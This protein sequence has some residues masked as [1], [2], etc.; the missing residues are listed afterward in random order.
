MRYQ[1]SLTSNVQ[2]YISKI[3]ANKIC[4]AQKPLEFIS[5]AKDIRNYLGDRT[6]LNT[7]DFIIRR[8]IQTHHAEILPSG[9]KIPNLADGCNIPWEADVIDSLSKTLA[10]RSKE[11]GTNISKK[12]WERYFSGTGASKREK[13]FKIAFTLEMDTDSTIDLLLAFD[14]E[15]YAGR[16]PLD[17]ICLFC[18]KK[19]GKYTWSEAEALLK[20]FKLTATLSSA[21]NSGPTPGMSRMMSSTLDAIFAESLPEAD[22]KTALIKYMVKNAGEFAGCKDGEKTVYLPG[23]SLSRL[24]GFMRLAQY[25]SILYPDYYTIGTNLH[26]E[27]TV[28]KITELYDNGLPS[29]QTLVRSMFYHSDWQN[30]FWDEGGVENGAP[31]NFEQQMRI[32][33]QNYEQHMMKIERLRRGG[34]N[35]AFFERRDAL[36]FIYFLVKGYIKLG[37]LH[38]KEAQEAYNQIDDMLDSGNDFDYAIAEALEKATYVFEFSDDENCVASRFKSLTECFNL[39][40]TQLGY[41]KLYLPARFDRFVVLALL[42][43][44]PDELTPLI[45]SHAEL[46]DYESDT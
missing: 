41:T 27:E 20:E 5:A 28:H 29:L 14:M 42:S 11:Y 30:I 35:I 34:K 19:P 23:Y 21:S 45:M 12:E 46:D 37:S 10:L 6:T 43:A 40:L 36:L 44:S 33:C 2:E 18:Q 4:S 32:L 3:L 17:L 22:E 1:N 8:F 9:K 7:P 16:H 13:V 15:A 31:G 25:L 26:P 38:G 24:E 39:I